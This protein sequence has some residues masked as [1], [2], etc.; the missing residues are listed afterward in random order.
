MSPGWYV[1]MPLV[2]MVVAI[3]VVG[4]FG[5]L[6]GA[7]GLGEDSRNAVVGLV[8]SLALVLGGLTLLAAVPPARRPEITATRVSIGVAVAI[9]LGMGLAFRLMAGI[10]SAVGEQ[11]DPS[12]CEKAKEATDIIPP[13]LWH[14][15]LL[16]VSLVVLA[17]LGEE[18]L[19]RGLMF[20]GFLAVLR[21]ALAAILA[22]VIFGLAH[23]QY[24]ATWS[25][26][27]SI[28]LMGVVLC[29]MYRRWGFPTVVAAHLVFNLIP[30]V[31]LFTGYDP[32]D[33]T[34]QADAE[35]LLG[36]LLTR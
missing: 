22:G 28:C 34:C 2:V 5:L 8:F 36:A 23:P 16:A 21:V 19:F 14:R 27:V 17:P 35:V 9:G 18:L 12:L 25:L 10:V 3:V 15:V 31:L 20:R 33:V 26:L 1:G 11:I 6:L 29:L 24:Y 7:L 4:V 13:E 32:A 30:A